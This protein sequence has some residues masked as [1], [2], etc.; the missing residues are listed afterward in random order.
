MSSLIGFRAGRG[1]PPPRGL[2]TAA[3]RYVTA[4]IQKNP[5]IPLPL[6][7]G[8]RQRPTPT[9]IFIKTQRPTA[10]VPLVPAATPH[11][12]HP[13]SPSRF[14]RDEGAAT[15]V[16]AATARTQNIDHRKK[17]R[18]ITVISRNP[19]SREHA[20]PPR[21]RCA[22]GVTQDFSGVSRVGAVFVEGRLKSMHLPHASPPAPSMADVYAHIHEYY[23]QSHG[24][25]VQTG[26]PAVL[27]SVLPGH[28]RSNKSL[29]VAFKVVALDDVQDGTLVTIKAG[30]DENAMAE[31]RNCTAVMKNQVAKFNDLRFVGRSGRGKSFSLTIT[32]SS[33][34]SQVATYMKAIKVTVDGPREPRTKQNY[35]YG[36]PG[37]FS[38]FLLNP[39]WLDAA[40]LN[41]AWADYFRPPQ[42]R[43]QT[44]TLIKGG[45]GPITTSPVTLPGAEL[46]PFPPAISNLPPAGLIPPPGAFL[47]PNGLLPFGP[48]PA[49]LAMKALPPE[50]SLKNGINPY[51]ALRHLQSNVSSMDT[52]SARLSPTSS[53]QSGSPRSVTNASPDRSKA[54][55]KS[56]V[57]SMHDATISDESDDETIEVVKS[58]FHPTR[59]A[60]VELQEMKRVQAAD[61]TVSDRPKAR[62]ELKAP[63]QRTTRMLSSSPT[64]TKIS[65]GS[66]A[67]HKSVWRPY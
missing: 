30:N 17:S 11:H 31:L 26:S 29:P 1:F 64:S 49:D 20:S 36:H 34:P 27:C 8:E 14:L 16:G 45:A 21:L 57:N 12:P 15:R 39:G 47:P 65:N 58:A 23:R 41:Y 53:R 35:G 46:F 25:L 62:N 33:F 18:R 10:A 28:W 51:E 7:G 32:I 22:S 56:E 61:S 67:T 4:V 44:A 37:A 50:L 6:G 42:M 63:S 55:S 3:S 48:H 54:D 66:L 13:S 52:S 24:E 19:S 60:N 38:P 5:P 2:I 9:S 59:P 43:D 40:Y